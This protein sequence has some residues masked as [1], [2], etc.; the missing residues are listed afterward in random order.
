MYKNKFDNVLGKVVSSAMLRRERKRKLKVHVRTGDRK[1]AGTDSNVYLLIKDK[2]GNRSEEFKLDHWWRNDLERGTTDSFDINVDI[3]FGIVNQIELH[4]DTSGIGDAWYLDIIIIED[5]DRIA[6]FPVHRWIHPYRK[7]CI[8]EYDS[9]P[10]QFDSNKCQRFEEL[11]S[12]RQIYQYTTHIK[13]GP[14]QIKTLPDDEMFSFEY[15]SDMLFN[16]VKLQISSSLTQLTTGRWKSL[17]DLKNVYKFNLEE[18]HSLQWWTE[19][20]WFG[21]QK[22]QGTNPVLIKLCKNIPDN[23][24]IEPS[25][26]E[27]F[28][29]GLSLND[30]LEENRIFIID[31]EVLQN[32]DTVENTVLCSPLAL[33]YLNNSGNLMPIAIQ[34]FQEKGP[35]NPVFLPSDPP[36]T[37][38]LAKLYFNNA[39]AIF[40]QSCTHLGLTHLLMEGVVICTH[41][42]LSPSHPLFRLMSPHFL[43]LLA[44]NSRGLEKLISPGGWVDKTMSTGCKGMFQLIKKCFKRWKMDVNGILP[45]EFASRGVNDPE[46]L[47]YYPY[48]DDATALYN[49]IKK[50]V[51]KIVYHY[52]ENSESIIEDWEL[53]KWRE[54]LTKD[55]AEGGVGLK[56]IPGNQGFTQVDE[57][58]DVVTSIIAICS[59]NH[60]AANF[61]QFDE[62]AFPPNYPAILYGEPPR[63]KTPLTEEDILNHL[64]DKSVTLDIIIITRLLSMK[65][66]NSLGDFEVQYLYDPVSIEAVEELKKDLEEISKRISERNAKVKHP[67]HWLDPKNVPNSISI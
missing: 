59:I 35:D 10:P 33:F 6:T 4:R 51:S 2:I 3:N 41:R 18:P 36:Y 19:D 38:L 34:L 43:Y 8:N 5:K 7:Y 64:P 14:A 11:T 54:E 53:Q 62:Y 44:I 37:W 66:T 26:V 27:P 47:H 63:D 24:E 25:M 58:V 13:D 23:F 22:I 31:L 1:G 55:K 50:Y 42:H 67:Y 57:I 28:L 20:Y 48:R 45:N 12:K 17:N 30:A 65:G 49:S 40:H 60:S 32:I 61:L 52:Y 15:V 29:E 39:D 9:V 56:G 46:I 16:K 21:L